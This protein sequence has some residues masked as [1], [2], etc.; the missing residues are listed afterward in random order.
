MHGQLAAKNIQAS[1][2]GKPL[3]AWK[4]NGG[5]EVLLCSGHDPTVVTIRAPAMHLF[6]F[7]GQTAID[8]CEFCHHRS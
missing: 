2:E 8:G 6:I 7:L 5:M 3:K 1:I 4:P